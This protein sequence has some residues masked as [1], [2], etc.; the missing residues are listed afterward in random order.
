MYFVQPAE[1]TVAVALAHHKG[2]V[3]GL[4]LEYVARMF[5][6]IK[7]KARVYHM[8]DEDADESDIVK[9]ERWLR[10]GNLTDEL[11]RTAPDVLAYAAYP[12]L[13]YLTTT[14]DLNVIESTWKRLK[15]ST[16]ALNRLQMSACVI[17]L[18][19][20][21]CFLELQLVLVPV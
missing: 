3:T 21:L 15:V 6:L 17:K 7:L 14:I 18:V 1:L 5:L 11:V 8:Q 20:S 10:K 13:N 12:K 4:Q 2:L 19:S 16:L 9:Y